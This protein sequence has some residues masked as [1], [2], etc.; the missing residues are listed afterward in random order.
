M[1]SFKNLISN[2]SAQI[3]SGGTITGDLVINGDLQVDGGGSLSFDEIIEGTQVID[4]DSTE[5]LLVR[6]NS[7][8]GDILTVNTTNGIVTIKRA[9]A[10]T[11]PATDTNA[12]LL[13]ENTNASGSAILRMR[14]GDGA[15]RIMYG[16]NN[17]T[18]KLYFSPRNEAANYVVIDQLG[19]IGIGETTPTNNLH[20]EADS[21]DE[22]ITIH[23]AG[24]TGNAITI[25]AN[26]SSADA[27]IGTMLGK[28]NGT[29]IGY[30]GFFSGADTTNK[31]DGVI[32]FATTPSG[33]SATV[34]LT[35][36]SSQNLQ[37][38]AT[39]KLYLDGG[40]NTYIHET[41]ADRVLI[42]VGGTNLLDLTE[43]GGGASD[44]LAIRALS[45][46][47]LDGGGNTYIQESSGD[48]IVLVT[49]G[50]TA[51]TLDSSQNA[52]FGG[53]VGVGVTPE[54]DWKSTVA[55]LQVGAGGSIFARS[56]SGETKIF[57]A[58][59]VKWTAAGF[60]YINNG[61]AAYHGLDAGIHTFAVAGSGS[62]DAVASFT[63]A[64]TINND[65]SSTF[66]GN[67]G[68][69]VAS[70]DAKLH[71][72][73][74]LN[75]AATA[76]PTASESYQLFINGAAGSTGDTVGIALGTTDGNDNVSA[77]MIAI[78]AGSAG[79]A[80]LAFYTKSASDT[81]ERMRIAS[82]GKV[83]FTQDVSG[84]AYIQV[85]NKIGGSSSVDETAGIRFSLGDGSALRGGGK[86][87]TKKELD[88][89]TSANMDTSMMFSVLQNNGWN[90]AL[91]LT[92]AGNLG[93]GDSTPDDKLS[94][95]G[96]D[97]QIRMGAN[98]SNHVVIGRNSSSGNFEMA[99]TCT[100]AAEEVFF[101]ATEN[102]AGALT[103]FTSEVARFIIDSNS[104]I[105]LSNN[106]SNT[107]NTVFG[108]SAWNNSSDNA[109]DYNT[110][111]G[112]GTMGTGAVAGA[113]YN[114][115]V[116][117]DALKNLTAGDYNVAIGALALD[118]VAVGES[119]NV[120]IG[121]GAMTSVDEGTAGGDADYNVAIG[122]NALEGGDFAGNDRQLQGNI[123]IGANAMDSTGANA[124]TGTIAI[125]HDALTALTS[126]AGNTAVGYQALDATT[127]GASNTMVGYETGTALP[128]GG[129]NNTAVGYQALK[130]ANNDT[131]HENT[132]VGY[133]A[134]QG[135]S[136]GWNNTLIGANVDVNTG[137]F[138]NVT[139]IGNNFEATQDDT[140]FLG[141]SD[142]EEVWMA[143]DKGAKIYAGNARL[144]D[145]GIVTSGDYNG[146][147]GNWTITGGDGDSSDTFIGTKSQLVFN[148]T[149][150]SFGALYGLVVHAEST[151]TADEESTAIIG[152]DA[153][154]KIAGTHSDV[155]S[156]YGSSTMT[157]IDGGTVDGNAFGSYV[158]VDID[159]GAI[160]AYIYGQKIDVNTTVNPTGNVFG[161]EIQMGGSNVDGTGDF[162]FRCHD[163]QNGDTVA[164][165]TALEGVATFD[166][167]DF[168]GA[169]DYAEYFESK[170]SK[171]IAIGSTVKLDGDKIVA[172][173]D[174]DT[175][176]GVI[177]PK[178]SS[179]VVANCATTR[180]QGK[181]L[182]TD[183]DEIILEDYKIKEWIEEIT[184]EEYNKRGKD[185]TGGVLGGTVKDSKVEDKYYR[186][187]S[188][189]IDRLPSGVTPP[190]DAV[191]LTPSH[192]RKK[193]NPDYDPSKVYKNRKERDEW[194]LVGLLGQ[195]PITKGQPVASN[196]IKMK[197]VSDTVEMYFVK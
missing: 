111:F 114:T 108:K 135:I 67:V 187:H 127:T 186:K 166:S 2:T 163:T 168:S 83:T 61:S 29:T 34:A 18:D 52:T 152:L 175:P 48:N 196:W 97:K 19:R 31:D 126:G 161:M 165:I 142:T 185:E 68:I 189:H 25:D 37:I 154:A 162:F 66:A 88:F 72:F 164:Q 144:Q 14:G 71:I 147:E 98:D 120:A 160:G 150:E 27:G 63:T 81:A 149:S 172:C 148:D 151:E 171:A 50:T 105:S 24:D 89:S 173:S 100:D 96:G 12:G 10:V 85:Q 15:A 129:D 103:F 181:Y 117:F 99:R 17:S 155:N 197:D 70:A 156:I 20:I 141:N 188:Y 137:S 191:E 178:S 13:I 122:Y 35:I 22:G 47:Y 80:D 84:D 121:L 5:A 55:G 140:V 62:A 106:D 16:E 42:T 112:E 131:S 7:D 128:A 101:R 40:G 74:D 75:N 134:G 58:E 76:T 21:G 82:D 73:E 9:D 133:Q 41:S 51:L 145:T 138:D 176:M 30:M 39:K 6:K 57:L 91:F 46:F 119:Y 107:G 11:N 43:N 179:A 26:R 49:G 92:S 32:K 1:A 157:N 78:D 104:R 118:A 177:R 69:G 180:Y 36:D 44:Y 184:F 195:I 113:T 115:G 56:D 158:N 130:G 54:T 94:I 183:Y 87:T 192:Q 77:S 95:Y 79:I 109:S 169:P 38:S 116:G 170:D 146:L 3:A 86:I 59:N 194:C 102:E 182:K 93:I 190:S 60:E 4:V 125:G 123:A 90:D 124:Q 167:G 45:K 139:A 8:G 110:I 193:L 143:S 53:A 33:G 64:L 28:W 153:T 23:S 65:A 174:G 132:V 136:N 159:G